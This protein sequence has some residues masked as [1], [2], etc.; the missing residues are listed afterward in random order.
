MLEIGENPILCRNC[1]VRLITCK[2]DT[3]NKEKSLE[4]EQRLQK[5]SPCPITEGVFM[6][7]IESVGIYERQ[8]QSEIYGRSLSSI[9]RLGRF[10]VNKAITEV[11]D[12]PE[13][14]QAKA[15][16]YTSVEEG[17]GTDSELGGGLE[18]RK[19]DYYPVRDGKVMA[20]D[21]KT[22]ISDTTKAGL[23]CA[24][25]KAETEEAKG[26]T[27]FLPQLVRSRWD[28]YNAL[29][30][31]KMVRGETDYNTRIVIS[32]FPEEAAAISGDA[33]WRGIGYVPSLRRGFVQLYYAGDQFLAGSLSFDGSDKSR[34]REVSAEHN[35]DIPVDESTDNWLQYAITGNY[36]EEEARQLGLLIADSCADPKYQKSTNTVEVTASHRAVMEEAFNNSYIHI[37]ESLFKGYQTPAAR[38]LIRQFSLKAAQFND[39]YKTALKEMATDKTRFSDKEAIILHELLVYST[40]E[41]MRALHLR[42][43]HYSVDRSY[44]PPYEYMRMQALSTESF[45]SMLTEYGAEGARNNRS[46][47]ACGLEIS[48]G[49]EGGIFDKPGQV[50]G[51]LSSSED[52]Y[53]S[54]YFKCSN[55]HW[56]YRPQNKL[57]DKCQHQNC[58]AKV[59]C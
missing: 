54:R 20:A 12:S 51:G 18:V 40:I 43:S 31:D 46:Y 35:V 25:D 37:C 42:S 4:Q 30:T 49:R 2:S 23:I 39:R 5:L 1:E 14:W 33:Y 55:G 58:K 7:A 21:L 45:Q 47:S 17:F 11:I 44:V 59:K 38:S 32:P 28:H 6:L 34:I 22:A 41:M 10:M 57:I 8:P 16:F 24:E 13:A 19:F 29:E 27:R 53:G 26:D 52:R 56:N 50:F 15:E 9:Y 36:S 48:L 3:A